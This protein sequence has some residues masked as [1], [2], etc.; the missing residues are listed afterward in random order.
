MMYQHAL[1]G[2]EKAPGPDH[3]LTFNTVSNLD[4]LYADQGKPKEAGSMLLDALVHS[5]D[6]TCWYIKTR[7]REH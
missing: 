4:N 5:E 3:T 1:K 6:G 7:L 2:S